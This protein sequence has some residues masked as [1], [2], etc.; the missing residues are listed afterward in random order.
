MLSPKKTSVTVG[1]TFIPQSKK[2]RSE[3]AVKMAGR[4]RLGEIRAIGISE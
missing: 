3:A 1:I 4:T 2:H